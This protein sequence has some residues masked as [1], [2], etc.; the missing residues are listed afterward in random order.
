MSV[1]ICP[2][3]SREAPR[4]TVVPYLTQLADGAILLRL[5]VQP[6]ASKT[7]ITG[8]HDGCLKLAIAA[9]PVDG[10][11]N[12]E[13]VKFLAE[14]LAIPSRDITLKSGT[15]GRRKQVVIAGLAGVGARQKIVKILES[16]SAID[17]RSV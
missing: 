9:P 3:P 10:R 1:S 15:Q 8:I 16:F 2:E 4:Q 12:Q 17:K 13:V 11:A 7:R 5:H 14:L 6:K